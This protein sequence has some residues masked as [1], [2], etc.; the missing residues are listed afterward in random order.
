MSEKKKT[1]AYKIIEKPGGNSYQF[2]C[3]LSGGLVCTTQPFKADK[4]EEE[5]MLA[6]ETAGRHYFNQCRKCGKWVIGVVYNADVFE[7]VECS[8]FE[9]EPSYCK[10]CGAKVDA[11]KKNC[12]SCGELL[13]YEGSLSL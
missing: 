8:P 5:L 7:C 6:W 12:P 9:S 2:F 4:P 1:A 3:D 13:I 10:N 11:S